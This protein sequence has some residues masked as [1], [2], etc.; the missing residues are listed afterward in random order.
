MR[1]RVS[2]RPRFVRPARPVFCFVEVRRA[3]ARFA[4]MS[5]RA[6]RRA[7][8][9]AR[10]ARFESLC[11]ADDSPLEAVVV[12]SLSRGVWHPRATIQKCQP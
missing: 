10:L 7:Q 12:G 8:A 11:I 2:L 3:G 6:F 4:R 1:V 9:R 5:W